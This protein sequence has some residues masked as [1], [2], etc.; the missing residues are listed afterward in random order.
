MK[1]TGNL[2]EL[3][4]QWIQEG[5][6]QCAV[7][8]IEILDRVHQVSYDLALDKISIPYNHELRVA[9]KKPDELGLGVND[10]ENQPIMKGINL[11]K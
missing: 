4:S 1:G 10:E 3:K 2:D 8:V 5:I 7:K 6:D 9:V 11:F